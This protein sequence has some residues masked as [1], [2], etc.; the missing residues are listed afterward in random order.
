M[1]ARIPLLLGPGLT[2]GV[3]G[4]ETFRLVFGGHSLEL[5]DLGIARL[6]KLRFGPGPLG[7]IAFD[8]T[9][10]L[11]F[12]CDG[13]VRAASV[14]RHTCRK[15]ADGPIV[16]A[17]PDSLPKD[18]IEHR[19]EIVR[20]GSGTVRT[21]FDG[22]LDISPTGERLLA[23]ATWQR[24]FAQ[25]VQL[26]PAGGVVSCFSLEGWSVGLSADFESSR[27]CQP[28]HAGGPRLLDFDGR[29]VATLSADFGSCFVTSAIRPKRGEVALGGWRG[30][31]VWSPQSGDWRVV[32][33]HGSHPAWS[34]DGKL[35][36]YMR[37]DHEL[38]V[39]DWDGVE[40]RSVVALD[41]NA[42][43]AG[44]LDERHAVPPLPSPCGRYV[45]AALTR[46]VEEDLRQVRA[47]QDPQGKTWRWPDWKY[48]R[49]HATCVIDL[50]SGIVHQVP[51]R[52]FQQVAWLGG[53]DAPP[54]PAGRARARR[55]AGAKR[56]AKR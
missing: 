40:T 55:S 15:V 21:A 5:A 39:V 8:P 6:K 24:A 4:S 25:L 18:W 46:A 20:G 36:W 35:L 32:D 51:G 56:P 37:E 16:K 30:L 22:F 17:D 54:R 14:G 34:A 1:L 52:H 3:L 42:I 50:E 44:S 33:L 27:I 29:V 28:A 10:K 31:G 23:L 41:G 26:D 9:K 49:E 12:F 45:I 2:E 53:D 19:R 7:G 47:P 38:C 48:R 13:S 43:A 11:V